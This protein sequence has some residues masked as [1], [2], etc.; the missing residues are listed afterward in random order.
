MYEGKLRRLVDEKMGPLQQRLEHLERDLR[1]LTNAVPKLGFGFAI[2]NNLEPVQEVQP[3]PV[4]GNL[5]KADP[6]KVKERV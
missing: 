4:L 1:E 6:A 5:I 3:Y 2:P